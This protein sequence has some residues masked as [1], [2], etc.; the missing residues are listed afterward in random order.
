LAYTYKYIHT[1]P[2]TRSWLAVHSSPF[3]P[4]Y[5]ET[6][7]DPVLILMWAGPVTV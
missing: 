5:R 2:T 4:L 7:T 3:F 6:I 1:A